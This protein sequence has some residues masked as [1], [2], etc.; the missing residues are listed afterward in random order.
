MTPRASKLQVDGA[1]L[2][3]EA[4]GIITERLLNR[5]WAD[6]RLLSGPHQPF[7][8]RGQATSL[9]CKRYVPYA[10]VRKPA[11]A[12]ERLCTEIDS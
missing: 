6:C 11:A 5:G 9:M 8:W 12:P 3:F 1:P 7:V 2:R 4:C 10:A